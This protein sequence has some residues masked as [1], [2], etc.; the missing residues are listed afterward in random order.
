MTSIYRETLVCGL[1][2]EALAELIA[3]EQLPDTYNDKGCRNFDIA[4]CSALADEKGE[5]HHGFG[6]NKNLNVYICGQ[7]KG[8]ARSL[9]EYKLVDHVYTFVLHALAK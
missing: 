6:V 5:R 3:E 1:L 2:K 7:I 8:A 4:A 9:R